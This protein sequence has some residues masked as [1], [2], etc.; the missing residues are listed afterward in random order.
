MVRR[1]VVVFVTSPLQERERANSASYFLFRRGLLMPL[2]VVMPNPS[3]PNAVHIRPT[4]LDTWQWHD[5]GGK[6][7][8]R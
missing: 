2:S 7:E 4:Y 1:V 5:L 3:N 6:E 8:E